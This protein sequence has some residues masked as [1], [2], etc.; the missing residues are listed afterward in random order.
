[1]AS[2]HAPVTRRYAWGRAS[3]GP[4]EPAKL[5]SG[6]LSCGRSHSPR[7]TASC[8]RHWPLPWRRPSG[9]AWRAILVAMVRPNQ[10]SPLT[11]ER[12]RSQTSRASW[13]SRRRSNR[14]TGFRTKRPGLRYCRASSVPEAIRSGVQ[15]ARR[16]H[17]QAELIGLPSCRFRAYHHLRSPSSA[18][19]GPAS[20]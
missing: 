17:C 19:R 14:T 2:S 8:W 5:R 6:S 3:I 1:M 7:R 18:H 4:F 11:P 20:C 9:A 12:G 13:R 10:V 16:S 15:R